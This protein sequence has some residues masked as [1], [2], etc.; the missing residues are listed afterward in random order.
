MQENEVKQEEEVRIELPKEKKIKVRKNEALWMLTFA[1][2]SF[3]LMCFFALLLSMSKPN[4]KRFENV[5]QG[6]SQTNTISKGQKKDAKNLKHVYESVKKE[7]KKKKLTKTASVKY[8][9][10]G[11]A[12]EFTDRMV[13]SPGSAQTS[14]YFK[15]VSHK[16]LDLIAKSSKDYRITIEGHTDDTPLGRSSRYKNNWELSSARGVSMLHL[17]K[18]KGI[19]QDKMRVISYADT[20]PKLQ[21]AGKRGKDLKSARSQNRRI[22]VRID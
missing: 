19:K 16:V 4:V 9:T 11:V 2:L 6:M 22:V 5:I 15:T 7:L 17:F 1:D 13:F 18:T 3:I 14:P 8:D 20:K 10:D 21:V 12:I